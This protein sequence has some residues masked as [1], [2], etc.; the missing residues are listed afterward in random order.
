MRNRR[1]P[2]PTIL[3]PSSGFRSPIFC[4]RRMV[5]P[6]AREL[7]RFVMVIMIMDPVATADTSADSANFPTIIRSTAP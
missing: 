1:I 6:M 3:P 5:I 2:L 7:T 4:P